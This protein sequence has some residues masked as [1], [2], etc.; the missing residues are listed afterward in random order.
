MRAGGEGRTMTRQTRRLVLGIATLAL[1]GSFAP[2]AQEPRGAAASAQNQA[3]AKEQLK[4]I[5]KVFDDLQTLFRGGEISVSDAR[6]A[7]WGRRRVE[8]L[9]ASGAKPAERIAALEKYVDLMKKNEDYAKRAH[10][11]AQ[12]TRVDV[13]DA[14]YR[15]LE[16]EMWLNEEKA[17]P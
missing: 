14:Q 5:D 16:A 10:E 8:A 12:A 15:R 3:L 13:A 11:R 6:F 4:L 2:A 7:V 17:K 9:L 1:A